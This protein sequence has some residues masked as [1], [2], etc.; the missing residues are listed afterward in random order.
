MPFAAPPPASQKRSSGKSQDKA[1]L[2]RPK[3]LSDEEKRQLI[4]AHAASRK[5]VD[6]VQRVSLVA[7]VLICALAI[8]AGWLYSVRM[9]MAEVFPKT[10]QASSAETAAEARLR[11][12]QDIKDGTQSII[13]EIEKIEREEILPSI[14][15][16]MMATS[17]PASATSTGAKEGAKAKS[18]PPG[19]TTDSKE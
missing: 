5:P 12:Q 1:S 9:S 8:G 7:G 10:D 14:K 17:T 6:H 16:A 2:L 11:Y 18:L 19:L 13:Q 15:S 4:M 3:I